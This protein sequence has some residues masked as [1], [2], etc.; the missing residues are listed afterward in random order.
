MQNCWEELTVRE[1]QLQTRIQTP[2]LQK[3]PQNRPCWSQSQTWSE[4][5][6]P[7]QGSAAPGTRCCEG[8]RE[9]RG[10]WGIKGQSSGVTDTTATAR[11]LLLSQ[12]VTAQ[13]R[14]PWLTVSEQRWATAASK[15]SHNYSFSCFDIHVFDSYPTGGLGAWVST[16]ELWSN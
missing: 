6:G 11:D 3:H 12:G 8:C 14:A 13:H 10:S 16:T 15:F 4:Q 1:N 5:V 7:Q 9:S 2:Y